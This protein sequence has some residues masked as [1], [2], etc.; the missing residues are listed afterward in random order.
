MAAFSVAVSLVG[1]VVTL[2]DPKGSED[3]GPFA[4]MIPIVLLV[5]PILGALIASREPQNSIGWIFCAFGFTGSIGGAAE[6]YA[7]VT[8]AA[9]DHWANWVGLILI[10]NPTLFTYF[11]FILL[12]FPDGRLPTRRWRHLA[13]FSLVT[14][15]LLWFFIAFKPG[16]FNG[17][18]G[19]FQI[20]ALAPIWKVVEAPLV[21]SVPFCLLASVAA[22][23]IR[24]RRSRGVE[25]QQLK[26]LVYAAV[27]I[28]MIVA[29]APLVFARPDLWWL[30]PL[31]FGIG[32]MSIPSAAAV[33][34]LRYRLYDI[35][36][37]I[38]R[39]VSYALVT[40][41][42]GCVF[43][44]FVLVPSLMLGTRKTPDY[45]IAAATLVV[46]AM[47]RP[48]R[49]RVQNTVD[50]RFNRKRYDAE[51]TIEAFT[52][53]LREQIDI[54][55]LGPSSRRSPLARCSRRTAHCG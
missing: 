17:R 4:V 19:T 24:F 30:W 26:W 52:L 54:D 9:E 43:A 5:F 16:T 7:T 51:H 1:V 23:V 46:A 49:R 11:V 27:L 25:R 6:S 53:R 29:L 35:D 48:V 10:D 50:H 33:A 36:R 41:V 39:T 34:I 38:S 20:Q 45:V 14:S 55:A 21:W 22:M 8:A 37:L 42:L 15:V 31:L 18:G 2:S 28:A 44:V 13:R 47:F 32:A 40:A 12:L 3:G